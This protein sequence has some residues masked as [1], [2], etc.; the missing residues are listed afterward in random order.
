M[1]KDKLKKYRRKFKIYYLSQMVPESWIAKIYNV[2]RQ[3]MHEEI[4]I[5][6]ENKVMCDVLNRW[7]NT[8]PLMFLED[9]KTQATLISLINKV[10]ANK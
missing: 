6:K 1:D 5:I 10:E 3:A 2:S 4:K 7:I 9:I 8:D